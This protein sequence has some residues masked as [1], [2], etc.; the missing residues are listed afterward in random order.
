MTPEQVI[1]LVADVRPARPR[2]RRVSHRRQVAAAAPPA[3]ARPSATWSPT[4]SR[5]IPARSSTGRSWRPT[6][7][8][9]SRASRWR[10]TRS[11]RR[12]AIIAVNA[13]LRRRPANGCGRRSP[14][15]RTRATSAR[16]RWAPARAALDRGPPAVR[17]VRGRRGDRAAAGARG[18]TRPARPASAISRPRAACA[19][20]RPSSTTSRRSRPCPGSWPMAPVAFADD[21]RLR[22]HPARR[23]SRSAAPSAEPGIVEV[24]TG[25]DAAR[26]RR[27]GESAWLRLPTAALKAVLVGGPSGGF[28]PPSALDTPLTHDALSCHGRHARLGHDRRGRRPSTCLVDLA[29]LLTRYLN[30]EACGKT[31]PCRIG[32]RRLARARRRASAPAARGPQDPDLLVD[33]RR[34][35]PRRAR[36]AD[37]SATAVNP[38]LTGMRYFAAGVRGPHRRAGSC[39]AGVCHPAPCRPPQASR[40]A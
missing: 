7:T 2:W 5:P 4:A 40:D 22:T 39:P 21:R 31:I 10:R 30:D 14:R 24:P 25:H 11:A 33:A 28:L 37:S 8:P 16:T 27:Y 18:S 32:T 12:S 23:S 1:R 17:L 34:R 38:L 26:D 19:A 13:P 15:P 6:R 3:V 20:S 36:C 9:S 35:H 29:T